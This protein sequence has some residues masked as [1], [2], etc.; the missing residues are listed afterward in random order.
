MN[1]TQSQVENAK[2]L[3]CEKC[4]NQT[5]KQ[6]FVIKTIS[7]LLTGDSKDM[8]APVPIFCCAKCDYVNEFFVKELKINVSEESHSEESL[9]HVT[10]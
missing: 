10:V 1:L 9:L 8:M 2:N 4:S 7:K 5:F 6:V 3:T